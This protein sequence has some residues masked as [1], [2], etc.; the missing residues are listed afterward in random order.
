MEKK[1]ASITYNKG[2]YTNAEG[3]NVV[4]EHRAYVIDFDHADGLIDWL[5]SLD[6]T[7]VHDEDIS[8]DEIALEEYKQ[9]SC[10]H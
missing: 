4:I 5:E 10:M 3:I 9:C 8:D 6:V 7:H 2:P 1:V